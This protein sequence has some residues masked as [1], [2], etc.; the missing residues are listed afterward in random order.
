MLSDSTIQQQ[1][2]LVMP[3]ATSSSGAAANGGMNN[4]ENG[5]WY[6]NGFCFRRAISA[7]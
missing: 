3:A 7:D 1:Q 2:P 5:M 6:L 4:G